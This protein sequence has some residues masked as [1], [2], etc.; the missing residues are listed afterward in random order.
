MSGLSASD[1]D[2]TITFEDASGNSICPFAD[3]DIIMMQRVNPGALVAP[4]AAGDATNII[5]KLVYEVT[6]V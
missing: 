5:K 3:G 6:A 4:S 1:D 2:G